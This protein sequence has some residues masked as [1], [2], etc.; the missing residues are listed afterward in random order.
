LKTLLRRLFAAKAV[1]PVFM[2]MPENHRVY[3]IGDIHGR[4]DL[5]SKVQQK[6]AADAADYQGVKTIIYLGDY[7]DRGMDSKGVVDCLLGAGFP[8]FN[9]VHLLGN[10]EQVL[11]QFLLTTDPAIGFNWFKFGGLATLIS[12]GV[13]VRGIPVLK[14]LVRLRAELTEKMPAEHL[15]FYKRL[16][17][18]FEMGDYY[19]VHAGIRPK[20]K[21]HQQQSDDQLWIREDFLNSKLFHGKKIVHGHT[22]T[23]E[24]VLLPN[25]IGLDTGAYSSGKLTCAVFEGINCT[26][27][28]N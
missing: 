28:P 21:L 2:G 15:E 14:D 5:L 12:Y 9:K 11:L 19:F 1:S 4:M 18:S 25:R 17:L 20:V 22:V 6:I 8:G 13:E 23:E 7:I 27:L 3:C 24:P 26:I 16:T 10:H